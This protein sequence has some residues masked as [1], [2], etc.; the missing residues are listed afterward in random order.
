MFFLRLDNFPYT[1]LEFKVG[2]PTV[3]KPFLRNY[4]FT[5]RA[6]SQSSGGVRSCPLDMKP[7]AKKGNYLADF[8]IFCQISHFQN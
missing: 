6:V 4:I 7:S 2:S 8:K 1:F 3:D 5:V